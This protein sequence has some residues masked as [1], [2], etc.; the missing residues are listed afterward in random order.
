MVLWLSSRSHDLA[1][2]RKQGKK[3]TW[4]C[5]PML[6]QSGHM[7]QVFVTTELLSDEPRASSS[8]EVAARRDDTRESLQFGK[9]TEESANRTANSRRRSAS[10]DYGGWGGS[11]WNKYF[12]A[13]VLVVGTDGDDSKISPENAKIEIRLFWA[14]FDWGERYENRKLDGT[15]QVESRQGRKE[16][17]F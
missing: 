10:A 12:G 9:R 16:K 4:R 8:G 2:E 5:S 14:W 3:N 1:R 15:K 13:I 11:R 17:E 7:V 6:R